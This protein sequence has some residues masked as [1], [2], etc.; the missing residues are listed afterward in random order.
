MGENITPITLEMFIPNPA[1]RSP[2]TNTQLNK[3]MEDYLGESSMRLHV[4][5]KSGRPFG[6]KIAR[7]LDDHVFES[8][9]RLNRLPEQSDARTFYIQQQ[10]QAIGVIRYYGGLF[11]EVEQDLELK[12]EIAMLSDNPSDLFRLLSMPAGQIDPTLAY[13]TH[14]HALISIIS[15]RH[16]A[17]T[18]NGRLR[19][20]LSQVNQLFNRNLFEGP[21]GSGQRLK[22]D[23]IHDDETNTMIGYPEAGK[24][25]PPTAHLKRVPLHVR[26]IK[27]AGLVVTSPRKKDDAVAIVKS[28]TKARAN[29][30]V[31]NIEKDVED[32]IGMIFALMED[33][34]RP[35]EFADRVISILEK[36]PRRIVKVLMD[37][38]VGK[39]RG[40]SQDL[41]FERRKIWFEETPVPL[42]LMFY[43]H[44]NYLNSMLEIGQRDPNTGLYLGASHRLFELRRGLDTAPVIFPPSIY[45][46]DLDRIAANCSRAIAIDLR[47]RNRVASNL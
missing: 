34:V 45:P 11:P 13:E 7:E 21:E 17:V 10:R 33:K 30:G 31:I 25:I 40:Q 43:D 14:R 15:S 9:K 16:N 4:R 28:I 24:R 12:N 2:E 37:N 3:L 27:G 47:G 36:G 18:L 1:G 8:I 6:D 38:R 5:L 35:V 44:R 42:E 20:V 22:F 41:E 39:G 26:E 19:T 29:G 46:L 32:G 23:S